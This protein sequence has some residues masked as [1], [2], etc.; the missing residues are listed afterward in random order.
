M[1]MKKCTFVL[2]AL[3]A[4]VGIISA[5]EYIDP[6]TKVIYTYEPGSGA[7][8]VKEGREYARGAD[9]EEM[10]MITEAGSPD[11]SGDLTI[12]SSFIIGG[13]EYV[14]TNIGD[15]AFYDCERITSVTIPETLL[16]IGERSFC[17]CHN[18]IKVEI[19][20]SVTS[21]GENAFGACYNIVSIV[22]HIEEPFMTDGFNDY[23]YL[24]TSKVTLYVPKGCEAKYRDVKGWSNFTEI[25]EMEETNILSHKKID[26]ISTE[27]P[28]FDLRGQRLSCPSRNAIYIQN[29]KKKL[30][31]GQE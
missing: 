16:F 19:S 5:E 18:L 21:I 3:I 4:F 22:S 25:V 12:L 27:D 26:Q 7:A 24:T 13:Q 6:Q 11:V 31:K 10:E 9:G 14:V 30:I 1:I 2:F 17:G 20:K 28:I 29:G 8:M 23:K 15:F